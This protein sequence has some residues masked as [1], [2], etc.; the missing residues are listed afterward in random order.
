[1]FVGDRIK[2]RMADISLRD[3]LAKLDTLLKSGSAAE[4][5]LHCRHI[6]QYYP[7]DAQAYRLLGQALV[8]TSRWAEAGEVMR[9]RTVRSHAPKLHGCRASWHC[10]RLGEA[11]RN[12]SRHRSF[13]SVTFIT[14]SLTW[15]FSLFGEAF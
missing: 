1:M 12:F 8:A 7:K 3:Y 5:I 15:T 2:S 10:K 14:L 11:L 13:L 6:L 4:V 9:L